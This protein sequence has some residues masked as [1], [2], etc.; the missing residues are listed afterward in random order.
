MVG[1]GHFLIW[2]VCASDACL[3]SRLCGSQE[4]NP[5]NFTLGNLDPEAIITSSR[6]A[7]RVIGLLP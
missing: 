5:V 1:R 6:N 2:I 4:I 7:W 3:L